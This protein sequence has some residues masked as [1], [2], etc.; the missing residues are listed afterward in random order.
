MITNK[1]NSN[2]ITNTLS[3]D[4]RLGN[5][6]IRNLAVSIMAEKH[7]LQ[8]LYKNEETIKRLGISLFHGIHNYNTMIKLTDENYF[9]LLMEDT[10]VSNL[11]PNDS[12]FQT[13]DIAI[14]LYNYLQSKMNDIML[15]NPFNNRY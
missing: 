11:N 6:I 15:V 5:Q 9:D 12:F 4:G 14:F 7:N 8:V 1:F 10:L 2:H 13:P 3:G